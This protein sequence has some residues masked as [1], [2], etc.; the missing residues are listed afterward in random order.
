MHTDPVEHALDHVNTYSRPSDLRITDIRTA[1]IAGAPMR[2]PLLRVETNQG[3]VGFGEVRDGASKEF[4]LVLKSRIL[5]QNPCDVDR[6]FRRIKQFGS[7]GRQSGG[8]SG[9]EIA[10]WD[11]AGKAYGVPVYQMLGGR[12]RDRVRVYCDTDLHGRHTGHAMGSAL[13]E[14]MARGFTFLKM[15]V[16]LPLIQDVPGA[17]TAPLGWLESMRAAVRFPPG[18]L[19]P[20][21]Q[22]RLRHEW[23]EINA[24][25]HP[26]TGVRVTEHGL[27]LLEEYVSEVRSVIGYEIPLAAD[28]FGHIG[29]E[30]CIKIARRLDKYNLAWYEDMLPWQY[31]DAYVRLAQSCTTPICTGEDIYLKEGFGPLLS[32]GGVSIIHP[33]ILTCGGILELK[34]IG[35]LAQDHGVAMAVHMAES[36]IACMAAVH[37]VAAT[38]NFIALENHSVDIPW[39][40]D[41]VIGPPNPIV[42][43]GYISVPNTPGLGIEALNDEVIAAHLDPEDPG[44]WESTDSYNRLDSHDRLWS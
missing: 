4:A 23:Y 18:D 34:K 5:G 21:E 2:C 37:A 9:I 27:D 33:D 30:D 20:D 38:E 7:H 31:T 3:L 32:S 43:Q 44:L 41:L 42:R 16:G 6:V 29:I 24:T 25:A 13:K 19:S 14:R 22:Q 26:F 11:L 10:L 15:D 28:H 36:P 12:F 8:V 39:W 40:N 35:D 17:L 1:T